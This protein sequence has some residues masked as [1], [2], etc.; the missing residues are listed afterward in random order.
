MVCNYGHKECWDLSNEQQV[1]EMD[2]IQRILG[3]TNAASLQ[4]KPSMFIRAWWTLGF[5][6]HLFNM[7]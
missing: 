3:T 2:F 6:I 7:D 5:L 4:E 1:E